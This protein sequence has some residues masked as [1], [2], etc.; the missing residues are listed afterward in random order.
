MATTG[1]TI[2]PGWESTSTNAINQ[3]E[4][5]KTNLITSLT[6]SPILAGLLT[7]SLA[8]LI[9]NE[10]WHRR[11][12]RKLSRFAQRRARTLRAEGMVDDLMSVPFEEIEMMVQLEEMLEEQSQ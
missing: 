3:T 7:A 1:P 9:L 5:M 6:Y 2:G 12:K 11:T 8:I 4:I 10:L